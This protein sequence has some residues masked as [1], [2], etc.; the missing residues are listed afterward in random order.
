[1]VVLLAGDLDDN[2]GLVC[3]RMLKLMTKRI[4]RPPPLELSSGKFGK[5]PQEAQDIL[6]ATY[7]ICVI[8]STTV[9]HIA[10]SSL[11]VADISI[12]KLQ[13]QRVVAMSLKT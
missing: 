7:G 9:A 12:I 5:R 8:N 2:A 11:M 1:M 6:I 3:A 10:E 4:P 13:W